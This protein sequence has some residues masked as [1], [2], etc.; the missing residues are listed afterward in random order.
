MAVDCHSDG[1]KVT[2]LHRSNHCKGTQH[3]ELTKHVHG[4]QQS[5]SLN[6]RTWGAEPP[7]HVINSEAAAETFADTVFVVW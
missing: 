4:T 1:V 2:V 3:S 6:G 5:I 7:V